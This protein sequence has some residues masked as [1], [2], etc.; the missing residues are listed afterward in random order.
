LR[1][2]P[3]STAAR[4]GGRT[5]SGQCLEQ[6]PARRPVGD[7]YRKFSSDIEPA[8]EAAQIGGGEEVC[9][10]AHPRSSD[11]IGEAVTLLENTA[12]LGRATPRRGLA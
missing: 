5:T 4:G 1:K 12:L 9:P 7:S 8:S 2:A 3:R 10:G 11:G 6:A